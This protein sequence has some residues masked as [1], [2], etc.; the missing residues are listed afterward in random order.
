MCI[1]RQMTNT[2][3]RKQEG[4]FIL[5]LI[6]DAFDWGHD[7][8]VLCNFC[9]KRYRDHCELSYGPDMACNPVMD[10]YPIITIC[11]AASCFGNWDNSFQWWVSLCCECIYV[12]W[13]SKSGTTQVMLILCLNMQWSET[14]ALHCS[15]YWV[16]H[17]DVC[18]HVLFKLCLRS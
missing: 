15:W 6:V 8:L 13:G 18:L 7:G 4:K 1:C 14:F 12:V 16:R 17:R 10:L 5:K 3:F 11:L 2:F 9:W